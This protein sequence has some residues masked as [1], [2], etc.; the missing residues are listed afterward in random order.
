MA[1]HAGRCQ[2]KA[3][4]QQELEEARAGSV[5]GD[6]DGEGERGTRDADHLPVPGAST[7]RGATRPDGIALTGQAV[8]TTEETLGAPSEAA[9][10][11]PGR[12]VRDF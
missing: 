3:P 10:F 11:L 4:T 1:Q 5:A 8:L 7:L 12:S 2:D 6:T 9:G